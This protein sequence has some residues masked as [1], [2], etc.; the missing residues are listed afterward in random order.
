MVLPPCPPRL[1]LYAIK[2]GMTNSIDN[3]RTFSK[4]YIRP[5]DNGGGHFVYNIDTMQRCS[6]CR[7]IGINKKPIPM[8]D[9]IIDIINKEAPEE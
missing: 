8:A 3:M 9:F 6:A 1:C 5:N 4:L 2:G 7:V